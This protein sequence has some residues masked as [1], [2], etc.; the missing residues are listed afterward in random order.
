MFAY[1]CLNGSTNLNFGTHAIQAQY[2]DIIFV[3][4]YSFSERKERDWFNIVTSVTG[5]RTG[6][7][8]NKVLHTKCAHTSDLRV[9]FVFA[10][11]GDNES[12][13]LPCNVVATDMLQVS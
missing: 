8:I 4:L 5:S 13:D 1:L 10:A 9:S 11:I 7:Q 2:Y 3:H 12:E 6:S